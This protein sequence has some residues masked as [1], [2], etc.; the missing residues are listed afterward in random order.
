MLV[1][2][3]HTAVRVEEDS[4][5]V[6]FV[7]DSQDYFVGDIRSVHLGE[8]NRPM[9]MKCQ[10][11]IP[12]EGKCTEHEDKHERIPSFRARLVGIEVEHILAR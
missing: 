12:I 11:L 9:V 4:V 2:R 8:D 1:E 7:V 3:Y 10:P 6:H 5:V